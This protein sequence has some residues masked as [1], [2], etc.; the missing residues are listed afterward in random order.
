MQPRMFEMIQIQMARRV[1]IE[2]QYEGYS[3]YY[4]YS[5]C[6]LHGR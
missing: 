3:D 5:K 2:L 4:G 6:I 1:K